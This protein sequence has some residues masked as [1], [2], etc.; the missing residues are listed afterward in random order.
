MAQR[1]QSNTESVDLWSFVAGAIGFLSDVS[2]GGTRLIL[3]LDGNE[4][5][6]VVPMS[7]FQKLQQSDEQKG[8]GQ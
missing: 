4:V 8:G 1:T 6:V 3:I 7:D 2:H 5:G